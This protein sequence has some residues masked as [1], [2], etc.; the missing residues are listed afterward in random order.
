M[1][2][3]GHPIKITEPDA[4]LWQT[5]EI[6]FKKWPKGPKEPKITKSG[7]KMTKPGQKMAKGGQIFQIWPKNGPTSV[8]G[9]PT[10]RTTNPLVRDEH[11]RWAKFLLWLEGQH[12]PT[13]EERF[14]FNWGTILERKN[15]GTS[16]RKKRIK[17]LVPLVTHPTKTFA[18]HCPH[19]TTGKEAAHLR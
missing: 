11:L 9:P 7:Q 10:R 14:G 8:W 19:K 18:G 17:T 4:R 2:K 1:V 15:S 6:C 3:K 16:W 12:P 13:T 5:A